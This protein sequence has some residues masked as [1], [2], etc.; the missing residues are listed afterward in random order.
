MSYAASPDL[1]RALSP[2]AGHPSRSGFRT[3]LIAPADLTREPGWQP[4]E[5]GFGR[6]LAIATTL[7]LALSLLLIG[8]GGRTWLGAA[9]V[10][11]DAASWAGPVLTTASLL[12]PPLKVG[13]KARS[14]APGPN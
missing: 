7:V 6:A 10:Q 14:F 13:R 1:S 4:D 2:S 3:T 9:W 8:A 11:A 5:L 12:S